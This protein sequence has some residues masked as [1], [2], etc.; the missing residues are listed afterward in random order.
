[1][2]PT[3]TD[4]PT[5]RRV[6]RWRKLILKSWERQVGAVVATGRYLIR[7]H[8]DL[9]DVHGAWASMVR[10]DLPFSRSTATK[11]MAIARHPVLS[12]GSHVNRLP[13]YYGHLYELSL[14]DS[15]TLKQLIST[16]AVNARKPAVWSDPLLILN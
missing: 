4:Q 16:G 13:A 9:I 1:M 11:L 5:L 6:R 7:A 12:S 10:N 14:F 15:A 2:S 8:D 3:L